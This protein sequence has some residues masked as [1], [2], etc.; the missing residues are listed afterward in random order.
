MSEFAFEQ[1]ELDGAY[2]IS[3]FYAGDQRGSFTKLFENDIFAKAGIKFKLNESFA[4]VSAKGVVRGMH[5]QI[6]H[7][8]AKLVSVLQGKAWDCIVD[9]RRDSSTYKQWAGVELSADN[10]KAVYVPPGF[11]HGFAALED[12]TIML[13]QCDGAYDKET[14]TGILIDD[15]ELSIEWPLNLD[16][17]VR[18]ERDLHLLTMPEYEA[19]MFNYDSSI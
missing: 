17:A 14:D 11:A 6:N 18:S 9:L 5:F 2:I 1:M 3:N 7:P 19:I 15:T 16:N 13:Y 10:H 4:S 8:Q 12:H